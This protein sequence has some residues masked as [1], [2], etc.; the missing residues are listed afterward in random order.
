M[1]VL[2]GSFTCLNFF[3]D[4]FICHGANVAIPVVVLTEKIGRALLLPWLDNFAHQ[5]TWKIMFREIIVA[6]PHPCFAHCIS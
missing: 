4:N 2:G 6:L 1:T 5:I 3:Y